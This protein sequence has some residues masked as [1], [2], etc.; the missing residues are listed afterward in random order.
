MIG[1]PGVIMIAD[2]YAKGIRDY[3]IS[4]A[5]QYSVNTCERFGNGDRGWSLYCDP[6][7]HSG[8]S[9]ASAPFSISNTL[10]NGYSEWCLSRLAAALGH[11]EDLA[12]YA[13]PGQSAPDIF[14]T[15]G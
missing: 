10:E 1:N 3:D 4:K 5:Y 7:D 14:R 2:A 15:T 6:E 13:A 12:L 8:S 9:Y 11:G